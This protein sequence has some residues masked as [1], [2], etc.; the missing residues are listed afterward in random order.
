MIE[1]IERERMILSHRHLCERGA[2]AFSY[3]GAERGDLEQIA[4]IGLIKACDRYKSRIGASF[5]TYAWFAIVS[6]L[7]RHQRGRSR[8]AA[9]DA[10]FQ[11]LGDGERDAPGTEERIVIARALGNLSPGE[12][13]VILGMYGLRMTQV[14]IARRIRR[15]TRQVARLHRDALNALAAMLSDEKRG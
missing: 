1:P 6:E 15:S 2:R 10:R 3:H 12:R 7:L 4:A 13:T 9:R 11:L 8:Q 14:E 5:E